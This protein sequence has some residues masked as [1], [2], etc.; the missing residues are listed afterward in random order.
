MP[1][2]L[3]LLPSFEAFIMPPGLDFHADMLVSDEDRD[4]MQE[5]GSIDKE[6]EDRPFGHKDTRIAD[7]GQEGRKVVQAHS[8][9][10]PAT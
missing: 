3:Y 4:G 9:R 7:K 8:Q 1:Y 10:I 5:S 2:L 6:A